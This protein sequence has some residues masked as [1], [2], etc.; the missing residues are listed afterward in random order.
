MFRRKLKS[1]NYALALFN[2]YLMDS[3]LLSLN[4]LIFEEEKR[5]AII[6]KAKKLEAKKLARESRSL[7]RALNLTNKNLVPTNVQENDYGK[8]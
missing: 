5:R 4:S 6:M 7:Q 2:S 1:H 8:L 3:A